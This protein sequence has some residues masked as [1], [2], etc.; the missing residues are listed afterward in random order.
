M[1]NVPVYMLQPVEGMYMYN[2][3][4]TIVIVP[5]FRF[6]SNIDCLDLMI[7]IGCVINAQDK[8]GRLLIV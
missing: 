3:N 4:Y 1:T 2:S 7:N 8:T 5:L 6:H